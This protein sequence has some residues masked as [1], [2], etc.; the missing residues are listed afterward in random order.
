MNA[1]ANGSLWALAALLSAGVALFSYRYL[2]AIGPR[3]PELLGNLFARPWLDVHIAGAA[4]A[5]LLGPLNFLGAIRRR[6]PKAHRWIGRAYIAGCLVGGAGGLVI[7]FGSFAGSVATAGFGS[8]A[9]CWMF[10]NAQG[11]RAARA[12]RF[13]DHRA[14]M[15]RS[16]AMTFA[17]VT[18]RLYLPLIPLFHVSFIEGYRAISF[19]AWV[20]NLIAAELYLR[21]SA[22][23]APWREVQ[24]MCSAETGSLAGKVSSRPSSSRS[25][26][27]VG[28]SLETESGWV[29]GA[30]LGGLSGWGSDIFISLGRKAIDL[31]AQCFSRHAALA[32]SLDRLRW[33]LSST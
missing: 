24:S 29:S 28:F 13:A 27:E 33:T 20:P 30:G 11:W 32:A 6:A 18:L 15:I 5:L 16:F 19:L 12:R 22:R 4:S 7:A 31:A 2:P 26:S 17:A 9:V 3:S 1:R 23:S 21:P 14:W 8:L 10:A 25:L